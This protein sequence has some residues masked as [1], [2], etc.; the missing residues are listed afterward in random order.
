VR[1]KGLERTLIGREEQPSYSPKKESSN[2]MVAEIEDLPTA[3]A[4]VLPFGLLQDAKR[5]L[6]GAY[7]LRGRGIEKAGFDFTDEDLLAFMQNEVVKLGQT[8][9]EINSAIA[10]EISSDSPYTIRSFLVELSL[11]YEQGIFD[12][13]HPQTATRSMNCYKMSTRI[14]RPY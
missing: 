11:R 7:H 12:T 6:E 14:T 5:F 3:Q 1:G 9:D 8:L 4:K 2:P 10:A 13:E